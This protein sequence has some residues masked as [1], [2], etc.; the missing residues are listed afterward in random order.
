MNTENILKLAD[1]LDKL[2]PEKFDPV[3]WVYEDPVC[4][5]VACI[6]GWASVLFPEFNVDCEG[7][8]GPAEVDYFVSGRRALGLSDE[9]AMDLFYGPTHTSPCEAATALK[10]LAETG[11]VK[12]EKHHD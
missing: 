10:Q 12:W 9:D 5:T 1:H 6:A 7:V 4:G 2:H 11:E 3:C 8:Y